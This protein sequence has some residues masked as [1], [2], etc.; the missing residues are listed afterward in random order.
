MI[1]P[2]HGRDM[3]LIVWKLGEADEDH[4]STALPVEDVPTPRAQPWVLHLLEVNTLNFCA[5]AICSSVPG[6]VDTASEV[7]IAVPN[8]LN[9]DAVRTTLVAI[10]VTKLTAII[11]R[12]LPSTFTTPNSYHQGWR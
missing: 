4:L 6:P 5:F 1:N 2:R 3:K 9:S 11:D 7:L 10:G 12:Y 8:T